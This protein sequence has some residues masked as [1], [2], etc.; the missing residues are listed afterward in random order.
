MMYQ[1][2]KKRREGAQRRRTCAFRDHANA[3]SAVSVNAHE[4]ASKQ[5]ETTNSKSK[6]ILKESKS[7]PQSF[8]ALHTLENEHLARKT[9]VLPSPLTNHVKSGAWLLVWS[10]GRTKVGK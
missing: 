3:V 1:R 7:C 2:N 5:G 9:V 6:G 4:L 8:H 10:D